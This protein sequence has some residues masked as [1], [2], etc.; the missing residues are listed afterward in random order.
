MHSYGVSRDSKAA[1]L[2]QKALKDA[3]WSGKYEDVLRFIN[4]GFNFKNYFNYFEADM[5]I[6]T[7]ECP[8]VIDYICNCPWR[9]FEYVNCSATNNRNDRLRFLKRVLELDLGVDFDRMWCV[10]GEVYS[11]LLRAIRD[12]NEHYMRILIN[13]GFSCIP[14]IEYK[15]PWEAITFIKKM[16]AFADQRDAEI[17]RRLSERGIIRDLARKIRGYLG[18]SRGALLALIENYADEA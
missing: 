17:D 1:V 8:A 14:T 12:E 18:D 3:N 10:N 13:H 11:A 7:L 9:V 6:K 16:I 5:A 2:F 15:L 4:E